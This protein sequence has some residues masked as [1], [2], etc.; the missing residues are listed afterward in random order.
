MS[1]SE[2]KYLKQIKKEDRKLLKNAKN[3]ENINAL[4]DFNPEE[5]RMKREIALIEA[6]QVALFKRQSGVRAQ[7]MKYPFV[8]DNLAKAKQTAGKK[9][10]C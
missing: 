8:Y 7:E 9:L 1:E 2:K 6:S 10:K 5:L 4:G 3:M